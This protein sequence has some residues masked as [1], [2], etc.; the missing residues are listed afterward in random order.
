MDG[1][2]EV[3]AWDL[4]R[5]GSF[6]WAGRRFAAI[7]VTNYLH[8]PL[9]ADLVAAVAAGGVLVYETYT[10]GQE[11]FGRPSSPA[12]LLEPGELLE[13]VRGRLRVLAYEDVVDSRPAAVQRIV[14]VRE[15]TVECNPQGVAEGIDSDHASHWSLIEG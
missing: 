3:I 13:A 9:L 4:E 10:R 11:R 14:A 8:R 1:L 5:G 6:P 15:A 12:F 7:V 2:V